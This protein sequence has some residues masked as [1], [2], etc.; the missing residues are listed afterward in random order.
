M[1]TALAIPILFLTNFF[2][3]EFAGVSFSFDL[4]QI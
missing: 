4:E 1:E 3:G 2:E